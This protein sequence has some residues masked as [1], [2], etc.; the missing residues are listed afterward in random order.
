MSVFV[1]FD[2]P[3]VPTSHKKILIYTTRTQASL[4]LPLLLHPLLDIATV[5]AAAALTSTGLRSSVL[6]GYRRLMRLRLQVFVGDQ[7]AI[8]QARLQL[9]AEFLKHRVCTWV[10][11]GTVG[12]EGGREGEKGVVIM[13]VDKLISQMGLC[14]R[15]PPVAFLLHQ[16]DLPSLPTLPSPPLRS[17]STSRTQKNSVA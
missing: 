8:D 17:L 11:L 7:Y 6:G 1:L 4:R 5:A 9:R 3:H 13:S 15:V 14:V 2:Q 16:A 10:G 12:R